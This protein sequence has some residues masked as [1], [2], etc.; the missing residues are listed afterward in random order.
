[1]V[2]IAFYMLVHLISHVI[3]NKWNKVYYERDM[4]KKV[5]YRTYFLSL[6]HAPI[7]VFLSFSSMFLVCGEGK[8]VFFD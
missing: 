5:D 6:F 8:N 3:F 4:I 1:M 2:F 7:A